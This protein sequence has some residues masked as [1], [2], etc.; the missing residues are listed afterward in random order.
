MDLSIVV[1]AYNEGK[2]LRRT[3][4]G[5]RE[6][7][8]GRKCSYEIIVVNDGSWDNTVSIVENSLLYQESKVILIRN[9][10]NRGKGYSV[11]KGIKVSTGDKVLLTDADMSTP[12]EEIEKLESYFS[13]GFDVVIGSRSIKGSRIKVAQP[14]YRILMGKTFNLMVRALVLRGFI[15]TQCGF[16]LLRGDCARDIVSEMRLDGFSFDVEM[17]FLGVR[18]GYSIKE[19]PVVWEDFKGSKVNPFY[20]SARMFLDLLYIRA[21]HMKK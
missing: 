8:R 18:K 17:L 21:I 9:S 3:L 19:V 7:F 10:R 15:D 12:I 6:Y 5:I 1:P 16:K 20:D 13:S 14:K 4:E 2:R 11:R